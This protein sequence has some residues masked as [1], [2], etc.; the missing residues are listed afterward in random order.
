VEAR[1]AVE[2]C[3]LSGAVGTDQRGDSVGLDRKRH[4]IDGDQ[5]AE[6]HG[7]VLDGEDRAHSS[8]ADGRR[9]EIRPFGRKRMITIITMPKT[10]IRYSASG[11]NHS[12][13][14]T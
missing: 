3:R 1:H 11:R 12:A 9:V 6:P 14:P 8:I 10:S 5:A 4:R 7:E 13:R 2:E